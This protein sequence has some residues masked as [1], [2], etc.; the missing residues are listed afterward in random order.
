MVGLLESEI[1]DQQSNPQAQ[2]PVEEMPVEEM[3]VDE[4]NEES[5]D[6][7]ST[8][9][10]E[11]DPALEA[12]LR[13][14]ESRLYDSDL[15]EKIGKTV[16]SSSGNPMLLAETIYK[17]V[18]KADTETEGNVAEENLVYLAMRVMDEVMTIAEE[19]GLQVSEELVSKVWKSLIEIFV[20]DQGIDP[21]EIK[22]A[23]SAVSDSDFASFARE[24]Q[25]A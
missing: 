13:Y 11:E 10:P 16:S 1:V 12:A 22:T 3:P 23:M 19:S 15:S 5:E 2:E 24:F 9:D 21:A 17:L 8:I 25:G 14:V 18:Q 6:T 7:E 20:K 4:S